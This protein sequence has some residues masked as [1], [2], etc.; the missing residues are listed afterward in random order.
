MASIN[1]LE[2]ERVTYLNIIFVGIIS[3]PTRLKNKRIRDFLK[4]Y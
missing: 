1:L 2:E 4:N 3:I